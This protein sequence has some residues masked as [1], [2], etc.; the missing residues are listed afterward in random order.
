MARP[1]KSEPTSRLTL[2]L[3]VSVRERLDE[4]KTKT[5]ADS[6]VEVI[7]RALAVYDYLWDEKGRGCVVVVRTDGKERELVLL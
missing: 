7:R 6:L 4:L 3:S 2:D 5:Q 1:R